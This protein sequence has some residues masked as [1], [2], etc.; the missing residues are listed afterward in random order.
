MSKFVDWHNEKM[1]KKAKEAFEKHR[2]AS[3]RRVQNEWDEI[4]I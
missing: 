4:I 2:F 1:L 3:W